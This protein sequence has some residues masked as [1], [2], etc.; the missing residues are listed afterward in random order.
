[1]FILWI[2]FTVMGSCLNLLHCSS[3]CKS[4]GNTLISFFFPLS[5]I[6][7]GSVF[8]KQQLGLYFFIV[9]F[10]IFLVFD[11]VL[12]W[13]N[14]SVPP[15]GGHWSECR[16]VERNGTVLLEKC[17]IFIS[18][19]LLLLQPLVMS[20]FESICDHS[21]NIKP[22]EGISACSP[23]LPTLV[24]RHKSL[25]STGAGA[26]SCSKNVVFGT[27][28]IYCTKSSCICA[29]RLLWSWFLWLSDFH[30]ILPLHLGC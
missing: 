13:T 26:L 24:Y 19:S 22:P 29:K 6:W 8:W 2:A 23:L 11:F 15:L 9:P 3:I 16:P 28:I 14:S 27:R 25:T 18:P 12:Q 1:M 10:L 20:Y 21:V 17:W 4:K 7:L 30:A 5:L